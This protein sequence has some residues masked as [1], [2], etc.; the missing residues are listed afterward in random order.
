M[1]TRLHRLTL[2][3]A[4]IV[5]AA[6]AYAVENPLESKYGNSGAKQ[7]GVGAPLAPAPVIPDS[8]AR[9]ALAHLASH[10]HPAGGWGHKYAVD[11]EP[12]RAPGPGN[13]P[14]HP[15]RI[16]PVVAKHALLYPPTLADTAVVLSAFL[17]A[18][19][20][21][22]AGDGA[23][24]LARATEA[25]ARAA[26]ARDPLAKDAAGRFVEKYIGRA[27]AVPLAL[28]ALTA[29]RDKS[30]DRAIRLTAEHAAE[31]LIDHLRA[32]QRPTG[33]WANETQFAYVADT[34][35]FRALS[36]AHRAGLAVPAD[37]LAHARNRAL[38]VYD[39]ATGDFG[40]P[41]FHNYYQCCATLNTLHQINETARHA[42]AQAAR[43]AALPT[44]TPADKTAATAAAAHARSAA[45]ALTNAQSLFFKKL[46]DAYRRP[47][48]PLA[49]NKAAA[50]P[51]DPH[52]ATKPVPAEPADSDDN[53]DHAPLRIRVPVTPHDAIAYFL[54]M[55]AVQSAA[56]PDAR[57]VTD[58]VAR[59]LAKAQRPDGT[60]RDP[61]TRDIQDHFL[62]AFTARALLVPPPPE[63]KP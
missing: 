8:A 42:A 34:L 13:G 63:Q 27:V 5:I 28:D 54:L 14:L 37:T 33:G 21:P 47:A 49:P 16:E 40:T 3:A 62:I 35:A 18:G 60:W 11:T 29:A 58:G 15:A 4:A 53:D 38:W 10:Q 9:K 46:R 44:A 50:N 43:R 45:T 20:T 24:E 36:L 51:L 1:T 61:S 19:R 31:R 12:V 52:P 7:G 22:G 56:H 30:A 41:S 32:T 25:L 23:A 57:P 6:P 2:A 59:A 39:P 48:N 55:E 17:D 26:L